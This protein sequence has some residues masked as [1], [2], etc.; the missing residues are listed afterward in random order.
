M[1]GHLD[2]RRGGARP[3]LPAGPAPLP[4]RELDAADL[5]VVPGS[6]R[7]TARGLVGDDGP[8]R[9]GVG[10][11]RVGTS[12]TGRRTTSSTS[13]SPTAGASC[14][15]AISPSTPL[16]PIPDGIDLG[17]R[18]RARTART[19]Q[20]ADDREVR[21][22]D[23]AGEGK[24]TWRDDDPDRSGGTY[25]YVGT[26]E[27]LQTDALAAVVDPGLPEWM[28]TATL[29]ALPKLFDALRHPI[30]PRARLPAADPESA[31]GPR[32]RAVA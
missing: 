24:L 22:L 10:A 5:R 3:R 17:G 23:R 19:L 4:R 21:V 9:R 25:A 15:R 14:T 8:N 20:T 28:R 2:V 32:D 27:A 30:G 11:V 26:A 13:P 1:D 12:A 16:A 6:A 31:F 7:S 29:D 18:P